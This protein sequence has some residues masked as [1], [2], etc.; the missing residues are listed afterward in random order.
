M[1]TA[2]IV[3]ARMSSSRLPGKVLIA[4]GDNTVLGQL[5]RRL[6]LSRR[7]D[8]VIV[9]IPTGQADDL[10]EHACRQLGVACHRG[11]ESDVLA[12]FHG[13]ALAH[14]V[15]NIVRITSDCPFYD[16]FLLDEMLADF[17]A[18]NEDR[19]T[20]D[21]STNCTMTRT[22]PRGL[23]TEICT[24][25]TLDRAFEDASKELEREHVTPYIYSN[26]DKFRLRSHSSAEDLSDHRWVVDT[27]ED[28]QFV[29]R[30]W[31]EL[32][33]H[34]SNFRTQDILDLLRRCPELRLMN[35]SVEQKHAD[36][37]F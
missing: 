9:A 20:V 8:G 1:K 23:D 29:E 12:R 33:G 15:E 18:A 16:P 21:Y 30:V 35:E 34:D 37:R 36:N 27:P 2:A 6:R 19:T 28:L 11:S 17:A 4:L 14:Q 7:L 31:Q 5:I 13:A 10:L 25:E 32:A 3:Q 22:Y 24:F 26:P